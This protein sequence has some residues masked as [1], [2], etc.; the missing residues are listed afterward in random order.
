MFHSRWLF[1]LYFHPFISTALMRPRRPKQ[2]RLHLNVFSSDDFNNLIEIIVWLEYTCIIGIL[3]VSFTAGFL[4]VPIH[5]HCVLEGAAFCN[6]LENPPC[7]FE[8]GSKKP[9]HVLW[10]PLTGQG[11]SFNH[12]SPLLP[13]KCEAMVFKNCIFWRGFNSE[14]KLSKEMVQCLTCNKWYHC[15]CL[16][17]SLQE[18]KDSTIMDCGCLLPCPYRSSN[19]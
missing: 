11:N 1:K 19:M 5:Q 2:Y 9:L 15:S 7:C 10:L 17:I 14:H 16:G 18:A 8:G 6:T 12:I 3:Q 4:K 13:W